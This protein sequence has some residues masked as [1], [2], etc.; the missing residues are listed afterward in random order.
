[1]NSQ[2]S[3]KPPSQTDDARRRTVSR[4]RAACLAGLA[5]L[6]TSLVGCDDE[7]LV[8]FRDAAVG[9]LQEGVNAILSGLVNGAFAVLDSGDTQ[10]TE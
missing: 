8:N 1:M 3:A 5:L 7:E 10:T 4:K 6:T 9:S 2:N